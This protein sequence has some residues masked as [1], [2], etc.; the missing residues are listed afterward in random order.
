MALESNILHKAVTIVENRASRGFKPFGE[1][2]PAKYWLPP[3][4]T[5]AVVMA[6]PTIMKHKR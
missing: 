1:W 5:A 4:G 3:S 2:R 6:D